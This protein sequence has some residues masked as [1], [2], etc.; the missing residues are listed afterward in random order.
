MGSAVALALQ[1]FSI[2][3]SLIEA[4]LEVK[5]LIETTQAALQ[6]MQDEKRD[7]TPE[8]WNAI[9]NKIEALRAQLHS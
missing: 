5:E 3:P 7:P 4:G 9:N 2:L 6:K 8:E 1:V